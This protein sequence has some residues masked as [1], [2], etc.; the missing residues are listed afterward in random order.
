MLNAK[1]WL[2][3]LRRY[4]LRHI[5]KISL[6]GVNVNKTLS[7]TIDIDKRCHHAS[8]NTVVAVV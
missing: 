7:S 4:L 3:T 2:K 1:K 6:V 5:K 8:A